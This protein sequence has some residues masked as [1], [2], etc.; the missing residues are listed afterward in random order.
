MRS[1]KEHRGWLIDA[2]LCGAVIFLI[3]LQKS[4]QPPVLACGKP[5]RHASPRD[6]EPGH[7]RRARSPMEIPLRGWKDILVRTY[8]EFSDDQIPLIAAGVTF[9][10]LLALFPALV[11]FVSLYGLIADVREVPGHLRELA[12]VLPMS[13]VDFMSEQMLR[14]ARAQTAGLSWAFV[15]GIIIALWSANGAAKAMFL[16]LNIAYEERERRGFVQLNLATL[17]FTLGLIILA[18]CLVVLLLAA[19]LADAE[20]APS[21]VGWLRWP[22]QFLLM[23]ATLSILYR[24]GPSRAQ[25]RWRW[26]SWG[27]VAGA[28][29]LIAASAAF[30]LYATYFAHFEAAYGSLGAGIGFL[31]WVYWSVMIVLA[32]AELNAEM[33]HQTAIDSTTGVPV[34]MGQRGATMADTLGQTS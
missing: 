27:S 33:E 25:P 26:V 8:K 16:G 6:R 17:A 14:L 7:G 18:I 23:V 11:S 15:I 5:S 19:P 21:Y 1:E 32:G 12:A 28:M 22:L 3:G 13:A 29:A 34:P 2:A 30:S 31:V 24:F 20:G 4:S 9:Y 10:I